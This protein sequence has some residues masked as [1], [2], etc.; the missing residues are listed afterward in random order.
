MITFVLCNIFELIWYS[1]FILSGEG[2]GGKSTEVF[3]M[4]NPTQFCKNLPD[5]P[6]DVLYAAGGLIDNM[7]VICGGAYGQYGYATKACY[8]LKDN[9]KWTI[10]ASLNSFRSY[11]QT[12]G[13]GSVTIN[14]GKRLWIT[15]FILITRALN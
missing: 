10:L 2:K 8:I 4:I 1:K 14:E 13:P 15:G 6:L 3:D 7:P 11:A 5:Y 12:D 9:T